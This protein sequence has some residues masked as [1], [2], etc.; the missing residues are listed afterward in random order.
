MIFWNKKRQYDRISD[1][2]LKVSHYDLYILWS[3]NL[4]LYIED[5]LMY[6]HD[7]FDLKLTIGHSDLYCIVQ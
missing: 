5:C 1:C 3:S 6:E 2:K 7:F 4:A